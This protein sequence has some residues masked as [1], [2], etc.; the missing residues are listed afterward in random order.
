MDLMRANI[1]KSQLLI[2]FSMWILFKIN[3]SFRRTS[4]I[5]TLFHVILGTWWL[6]QNLIYSWVLFFKSNKGEWG[7][8]TCF[9]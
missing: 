5:E 1:K 7:K 6:M 3:I 2:V 9:I 8:V 4:R